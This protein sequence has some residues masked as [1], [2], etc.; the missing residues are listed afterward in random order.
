[1]KT[2]PK[3]LIDIIKFWAELTL[4]QAQDRVRVAYRSP[5]Q[6]NHMEQTL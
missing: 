5:V 1:M 2:R 4:R 6:V 3:G